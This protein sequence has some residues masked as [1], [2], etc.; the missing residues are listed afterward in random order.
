MNK[1]LIIGCLAILVLVVALIAAF[2]AN[3]GAPYGT[4]SLK[5]VPTDATVS[6]DNHAQTATDSLHLT[7]GTHSVIIS[8]DGFTAQ[9]LSVTIT[10]N[11]TTSQT[12]TLNSANATGQTYLDNYAQNAAQAQA[13]AGAED[14]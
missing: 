10:A 14:E 11:K 4:L 3:L 6:V 1:K 5:I 2:K 9:T 12:V 7:A 8:R 13:A